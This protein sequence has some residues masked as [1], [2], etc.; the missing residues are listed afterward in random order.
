MSFRPVRS[1]LAALWAG[2]CLLVGATSSASE[3]VRGITVPD[4]DGRGLVDRWRHAADPPDERVERAFGRA[5]APLEI[6]LRRDPPTFCWVRIR[7]AKHEA[8]IA[9]FDMQIARS[10]H[11]R[12]FP[13]Q[14]KPLPIG[15][16]PPAPSEGCWILDFEPGE[17]FDLPSGYEQV[18]SGRRFR[19]W[20]PAQ[21][22][23]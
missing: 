22:A 8:S 13:A 16:A 19:L 7:T 15:A 3:L 10:L 23:R 11:H 20:R 17:P 14:Y 9:L 18:E 6:V 21:G 2:L 4:A 12:F 5:T 1:L